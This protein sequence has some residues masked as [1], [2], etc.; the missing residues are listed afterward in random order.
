VVVSVVGAWVIG[1]AVLSVLSLRAVRRLFDLRH[2]WWTNLPAAVLFW[3]MIGFVVV[4]SLYSDHY[5][6]RIDW[7]PLA[8]SLLLIGISLVIDE[9]WARQEMRKTFNWM[10][11]FDEAAVGFIAAGFVVHFRPGIQGPRLLA[12]G[13]AVAIALLLELA[14]LF[15]PREDDVPAENTSALAAELARRREAGERVAYWAAQN[16]GWLTGLIVAVGALLLF[17]IMRTYQVFPWVSVVMLL[18]AVGLVL[19]YG[20][21]RVSVNQGLLEV[22]LGMLG[23]QLLSLPTSEIADAS[24]HPFAPLKDFGGYGVRGNREMKAYFFR[25]NRG[26]KV[27][28]RQGRQYLIGSDRPER[29]ATALTAVAG[30][31]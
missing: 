31:G 10:S 19:L 18:L 24:V 5:W 25:G 9:L 17:G 6:H 13:A 3:G 30:H 7:D 11:L 21:L 29:L 20:G 12:A 2:P 8:I 23:I 26:V 22:R 14:R 27:R 15:V 16:P 28:T 1:A 4:R